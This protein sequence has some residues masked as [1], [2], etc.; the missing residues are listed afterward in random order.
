MLGTSLLG[1]CLISYNDRK[2][3]KR[4]QHLTPQYM[5]QALHIGLWA[6]ACNYST[7]LILIKLGGSIIDTAT[8]FWVGNLNMLG[9]TD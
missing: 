6:V 3:A 8:N 1:K 5:T 7:N 2:D 9:N 4:N